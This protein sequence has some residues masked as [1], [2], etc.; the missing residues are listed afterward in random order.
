M[1][2]YTQNMARWRPAVVAA[3]AILA[4]ANTLHNGFVW[5]DHLFVENNP[6]LSQPRA[7]ARPRAPGAARPVFLL[8]LIVDRDIGG[9]KPAGCHLTNVLLHAADSL[10]GYALASS[11]LPAPAAFFSALLFALH[12][13]HTESVDVITFRSDLLA[14]FFFFLAL[15]AYRACG[16][17]RGFAAKAALLGASA[18][19]YLLGLLSKE[20]AITMPALALL[21]D[22]TVWRGMRSARTRAAA[23]VV[24][25]AVAG[26]YLVWRFP[27]AD[28]GTGLRGSRPSPAANASPDGRRDAR[29]QAWTA[30]PQGMPAPQA[31]AYPPSRPQWARAYRAPLERA[32][33]MSEVFGEYL[34]LMFLPYGLRAD[35]LPPLVR[36]WRAPGVW[37]SWL[38]MA[39][40][41]GAGWRGLRR[42]RMPLAFGVGWTFVAL[43][44]VSDLIPIY[45]PMAERYLYIVSAGPCWI[46][47]WLWGEI[48]GS[49]LRSRASHAAGL[50]VLLAFAAMTVRRNREWISDAA[51]FAG[52]RG[53]NARVQYN[54][55]VL[56]QQKGDLET[57][58]ARYRRAIKANPGYSEAL[59]NLAGVEDELGEKAAARRDYLA[60]LALSPSAPIPYD[61]YGLFLEKQGA[62]REAR[63]FYRQALDKEPGFIPARMHLAA[64]LAAAGRVQ[65]AV[66]QYRDVIRRDPFFRKAYVELGMLCGR[67]GRYEEAAAALSS[68]TARFPGEASLAENLGVVRHHEGKIAEALRW[69][70]R[71]E[72]INPRDADIRNN[73]GMVYADKGDLGKAREEFK[74]AV[75]LLPAFAGAWFNLGVVEQRLGSSTGAVAAYQRAVGADPRSIRAINNLSG[76]YESSGRL[77]EARR[78][79]AGG[80]ALS[81]R[82]PFLHAN[83]GNVALAEGKIGQAESE[84]REALA[85]APGHGIPRADLAPTLANLGL[86]HLKRGEAD[87]AE[88]ILRR[89]IAAN[90]RYTPSYLLLGRALSSEGRPQEAR[91][92]LEA[93]L[94]LDPG[95]RD[96]AG[97]LRELDNRGP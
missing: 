8:S 65:L 84:Y 57:A 23:A 4:Y 96:A 3:A 13:I 87:K 25:A 81:P 80:L 37:L 11:F 14:C 42:G 10:L 24:Y 20:M 29:P 27:R 93:L 83:L 70:N 28:Y 89:A 90:P 63:R 78:L 34:R 69:L 35:R 41:L 50:L 97:A 45:N 95:N 39:A 6:A 60:A 76:L 47:G 51:I 33:S 32:L 74:A 73:L 77:A 38:L 1:A 58:G 22:G 64:N 44:P 12:P 21:A 54:L 72:A 26:G 49:S 48:R 16:K 5:D 18:G 59:T 55:G 7:A 2:C 67:E 30:P 79:L 36:S 19:C 46:L 68:G 31:T 53:G 15:L 56:A 40:F 43:A 94:R 86:C 62:R 9:L 71:A 92:A 85:E 61:D 88:P 52:E 75:G 82:E 66:N 17:D 91:A